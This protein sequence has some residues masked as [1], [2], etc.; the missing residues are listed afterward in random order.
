MVSLI[1]SHGDSALA[2]RSGTSVRNPRSDKK[3]ICDYCIKG[4]TF[5][6]LF[7]LYFLTGCPTFKASCHATSFIKTFPIFPHD[8]L[9]NINSLA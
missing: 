1:P 6:L 4:A 5:V 7:I 2:P 3:S 8:V 9:V